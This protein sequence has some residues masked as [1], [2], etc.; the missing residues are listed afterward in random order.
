MRYPPTPPPF[1]TELDSLCSS[2]LPFNPASC[3]DFLSCLLGQSDPASS[4]SALCNPSGP[5]TRTS[6][7]Q[8]GNLS[9]ASDA[10]SPFS[11][12]TVPCQSPN[13][14]SSPSLLPS[15]CLAFAST[16]PCYLAS[17]QCQILYVKTIGPSSFISPILHS[18]LKSERTVSVAE[19]A[20]LSLCP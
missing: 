13:P 14:A 9:G 12:P 8:P 7:A 17:L 1:L 3:L 5:F 15:A 19:L 18:S 4:L 6:V 10:T 16:F 11:H 2:C 20:W